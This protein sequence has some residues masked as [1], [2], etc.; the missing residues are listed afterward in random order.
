MKAFTEGF[1]VG[2][3]AGAGAVQG[4]GVK[5]GGCGAAGEGQAPGD[6]DEL[7]HFS[8]DED[9][10]DRGGQAEGND[11]GEGGVQDVC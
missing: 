3:R 10:K 8:E 4:V 2:Q 5:S 9:P 11:P 6:D 7:P 1:Q